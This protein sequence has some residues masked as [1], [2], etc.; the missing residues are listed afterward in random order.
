MFHLFSFLVV[1]KRKKRVFFVA[2]LALV[3]LCFCGGVV[4]HFSIGNIKTYIQ[5]IQHLT[6]YKKVGKDTRLTSTRELVPV[7]LLLL[8]RQ[9]LSLV[10]LSRGELRY[11]PF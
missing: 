8:R 11:R 10:A 4:Q 7:L 2:I 3:V 5:Y 9:P 1:E 6:L